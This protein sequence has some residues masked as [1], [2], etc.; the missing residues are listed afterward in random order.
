MLPMDNPSIEG[1][2]EFV[3]AEI[4]RW[5]KVVEQAGLTGSQ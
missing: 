4:V 5:G 2:Q 3:R 1:L